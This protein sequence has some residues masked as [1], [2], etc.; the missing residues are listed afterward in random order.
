MGVGSMNKDEAQRIAGCIN[1]LRPDW[2]T[3]GLMTILG[4]DRNR[5]RPMTDVCLAF[6]ALALDAKSRKP[7]RI[8]EHG[9][10]WE[11]LAPR[12]GSSVQYKTITDADC[13]ICSRPEIEHPLLNDDH[14]W[15]PQHARIESHV[16]TPEQRAALDKAAAEA[17][18]KVTA[19][20]EA[21]EERK[22]R[23]MDDVLASHAPDTETE[24]VA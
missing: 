7:T 5:N 10:W 1:I 3:N 9:P 18:A 21:A 2:S 19:E 4:D 11:L 22:V 16:P 24:E 8:Y 13:A 12:V 23:D 6:V 20:R 14:K 15:E 17:K